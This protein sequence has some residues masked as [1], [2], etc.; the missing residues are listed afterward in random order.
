MA[1]ALAAVATA[2]AQIMPTQDGGRLGS[3]E[4]SAAQTLER[5]AAAQ[6]V[7]GRPLRAGE[8]WYVRTR[9]EWLTSTDLGGGVSFVEPT[10]REDWIAID[11]YRGFRTRN[12]GKPQFV[13]P[14]D[15]ARW[16]A[17]GK[18]DVFAKH[19]GR[20]TRHR[21]RGS[22]AQ[23]PFYEGSEQVSYRELLDLPRDPDTLPRAAS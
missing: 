5:A 8:Y 12:T 3:P 23:A 15:R 1:A 17:A 18:P 10:L 22:L 14:R 19:D 6:G 16:V 2:I 21:P 11:G 9:A 20:M 7:P 4:A 13:G